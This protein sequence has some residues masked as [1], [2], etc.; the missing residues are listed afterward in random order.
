MNVLLIYPRYP[1][2]FWSFRDALKFISKKAA[3]PPLGLITIASMLPKSWDLKLIDLNV[4]KLKD[5]HIKNADL[6][7]ISAM[8]IQSKSAREVINKC[9]EYGVKV[10]AGG[11]AFTSEPEKFKDVDYLILDEGE[12]T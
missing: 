5:K 4:E 1:D 9:K 7:M 6:V 10:A 2:T 12:L 11:P 8:M 3:F